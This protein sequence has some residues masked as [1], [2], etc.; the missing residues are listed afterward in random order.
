MKLVAPVALMIAA[1]S[2]S[3][4]AAAPCPGVVEG[5]SS[6][7]DVEQFYAERAVDIVKA[8]AAN[9]GATLGK[10]VAPAFTFELWQGD[11]ALGRKTGVAGA[12]EMVGFIKPV[13]AQSAIPVSGPVWIASAPEQGPKCARNATLLLR[14]DQTDRAYEI[15]F[16]FAEGRLSRAHGH[17]A[18][19]VESTFSQR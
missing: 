12:I 5:K 16:D 18:V 19:V 10:L 7:T 15:R 8:A 11:N 9:D 6:P 17:Q 1:P 4:V 2:F 13:A 14:T 3:A